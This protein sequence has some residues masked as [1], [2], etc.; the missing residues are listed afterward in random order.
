[1]GPM[2]QEMS[3]RSP[4]CVA[5]NCSC[6]H[7]FF[8]SAAAKAV[9]TVSTFMVMMMI[10]QNDDNDDMMISNS[11]HPLYLWIHFTII[12]IEF[13]QL[14]QRKIH[15]LHWKRRKEERGEKCHNDTLVM[16]IVSPN[17]EN[18]Q[19]ELTRRNK[20]CMNSHHADVLV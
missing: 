19:C 15:P 20:E 14:T 8:D 9:T 4:S 18:C 2:A 3:I 10:W 1:M 12:C 11:S 5:N 16:T 13:A 7:T 17:R 6:C